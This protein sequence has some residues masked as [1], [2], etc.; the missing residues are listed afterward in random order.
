MA[1]VNVKIN[2]N[3]YKIEKIGI[4]N[5]DI[6]SCFDND[7]LKTKI[8]FNFKDIVLTR[9]NKD[10]LIIIDFKKS[11]IKYTLKEQ[12]KTFL[13]KFT[14]LKLIIKT[15]EAIINYQIGEDIFNLRIFYKYQ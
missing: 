11:I 3:E 6:L 4:I 5:N 1:K 2:I 14:I 15:K 9:E 13:N 8:S 7:L 12:N 10:I